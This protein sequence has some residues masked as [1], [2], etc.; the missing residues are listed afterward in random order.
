[1]AD[2]QK[3]FDPDAFMATQGKVAF[4]PDAFMAS[5]SSTT[6]VR[7]MEAMG[8]KAPAA[9]G[10][11]IPPALQGPPVSH[12]GIVDSA[13][14]TMKA[15]PGAMYHSLTSTPLTEAGDDIRRLPPPIPINAPRRSGPMT[16]TSEA[17]LGPGLSTDYSPTMKELA[18]REIGN[19]VPAVALSALGEGID[20]PKVRG[21]VGGAARAGVNRILPA[22]V[23]GFAMNRF[24]P[25][26]ATTLG[27]AAM[28]IPPM[29]KGGMEGAAGK[30]WA[31]P[32]ATKIADAVMPGP[33][34]M[35]GFLNAPGDTS[36]VRGVN[37]QY[38]E[39]PVLTAGSIRMPGVETPDASYVRGVPAYAHPP[40]PR[41]ALTAGKPPI[42][43]PAPPAT[44]DTS[45]VRGVP[46]MAHP[47]NPARALLMAGPRVFE[48]PAAADTSFVRSVPAE[49]GAKVAPAPV[50][51]S[52][53]GPISPEVA[54]PPVSAEAPQPHTGPIPANMIRTPD[55]RLVPLNVRRR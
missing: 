11:I 32:V 48:M 19:L 20:S 49:Y 52:R 6:P 21:F 43:T 54:P 8:G 37:A 5:Q 25:P 22:S 34:P 29:V 26:W 42:V 12:Q 14:D 15:W 40:D 17:N 9:G 2:P 53:P 23:A 18:G 50:V 41:R 47:P 30:P 3:P 1:M 39:Q 10:K 7:G 16:P 55:G 4:D 35:R 46:A 38:G 31:G 28:T 44:A 45:Y 24:L 13:I 27:E 36:F 33:R 51:V